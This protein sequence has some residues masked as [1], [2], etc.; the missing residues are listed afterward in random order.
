MGKDGGEKNFYFYCRLA[1]YVSA[2]VSFEL[3]EYE[4][5]VSVRERK[6]QWNQEV[7]ENQ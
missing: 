4:S 1:C 6:V 7:F 3:H 5:E 2:Y